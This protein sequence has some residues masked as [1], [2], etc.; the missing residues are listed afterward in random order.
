MDIQSLVAKDPAT[1]I[2]V[3]LQLSKPGTRH[4]DRVTKTKTVESILSSLDIQGITTYI[5]HLLS[6]FNLDEDVKT[7]R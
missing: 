7:E 6:Q 1:G 4:F 5:D 2:T 3:I